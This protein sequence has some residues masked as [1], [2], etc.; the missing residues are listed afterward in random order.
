MRV[1]ERARAA[2]LLRNIQ[3]AS[4]NMSKLFNQIAT[5]KEVVVP[6]DA[7]SRTGTIMRLTAYLETLTQ[8][9]ESAAVAQSFA[10]VATD[11]L[12]VSADNL[13]R[14][15]TL[16]SRALNG[17]LADSQRQAIGD[18]MNDLLES[19]VQY[20]NQNFD[21]RYIFSGTK[22][23]TPPLA[24]V[25]DADGKIESINYQGSST[26]LEFPIS[27]DRTLAPSVTG[28]AAFIDTGLVG[29]LISVRDHLK[30]VEGLSESEQHAALQTDFENLAAAEHSFFA[31]AGHVGSRA[32]ELDM[33]IQQSENAMTRAKEAVSRVRDADMAEISLGLQ[34][35]QVIYQ[36]LL[37]AGAQIMNISLMDYLG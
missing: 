27:R 14:A 11:T 25:R 1:T 36:A 35:E 15:R 2:D 22:T 6:S 37:A 28:E 31:V 24:V 17:T 8:N 21:G 7:P 18:E 16:V 13:L 20:A 23:D 12:G 3:I 19:L 10:D 30:N 5:Q 9:S 26:P 34:R 32:A 33:V 29:A 4:G